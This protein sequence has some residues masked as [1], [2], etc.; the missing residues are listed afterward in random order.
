MKP[1]RRFTDAIRARGTQYEELS[2]FA[3]ISRDRE[4]IDCGGI[5]CAYSVRIW[6]VASVDVDPW[7]ARGWP[8][9][10]T[11]R[12]AAFPLGLLEKAYKIRVEQG[13]A[14]RE[15]D[16]VRILNSI[17]KKPLK[18]KPAS[19]HPAYDAVTCIIFKQRSWGNARPG[20]RNPLK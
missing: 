16:R 15:D 4:H 12:E 20:A 11:D 9:M 18:S 7:R 17:A 14:S 2:V 13:E 3:N 1:S 5:H 10:K 19:Q 6:T 8:P